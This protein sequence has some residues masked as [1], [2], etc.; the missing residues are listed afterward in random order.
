MSCAF[1]KSILASLWC[2]VMRSTVLSITFLRVYVVVLLQ[3]EV[4]KDFLVDNGIDPAEVLRSA[5]TA[6]SE[7][8]SIED[9]EEASTEDDQEEEDEDE[10]DEKEDSMEAV[11]SIAGQE[12]AQSPGEA[13]DWLCPQM[14]RV[15]YVR[16]TMTYVRIELVFLYRAWNTEHGVKV[17]STYIAACCY[18]STI[19][20][21][22]CL[23]HNQPSACY[24]HMPRHRLQACWH[25][26][27]I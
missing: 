20:Y 27:I 12:E 15:L 11:A 4:L 24:A 14:S 6:L 19:V 17:A 16:G 3:I 23:E 13:W 10:V 26:L 25:H 21:T 2:P 7:E 9:D 22:A 5:Q 8:D 1:P 18:T